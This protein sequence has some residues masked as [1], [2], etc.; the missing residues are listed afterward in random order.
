MISAFLLTSSLLA[1][2]ENTTKHSSR[3]LALP[4]ELRNHIYTF[5]IEPSSPIRSRGPRKSTET[6]HSL[7]QYGSLMHVCHQTR[8]EFS[9]MY[10]ARTPVVL[11]QPA[12]NLYIQT[13]YPGVTREIS[14]GESRSANL[15]DRILPAF[16]HARRDWNVQGNIHVASYFGFQFNAAVLVHLCGCQLASCARSGRFLR[17][18]I[19]GHVL[20]GHTAYIRGGD[21]SHE[22]RAADGVSGV[23]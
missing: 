16:T 9:P 23:S 12:V 6:R 4:G 20:A 5:C 3:L 18:R 8:T 19:Y 7:G 10:F 1:Q 13:F 2:H 11:H 15:E 17:R 14:K 22:S 21:D